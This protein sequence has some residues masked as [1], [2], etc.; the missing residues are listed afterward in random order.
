MS[1]RFQVARYAISKQGIKQLEITFGSIFSLF[2]MK[3]AKHIAARGNLKLP[4]LRPCDPFIRDLKMQGRRQQQKRYFK[5]EFTFLQPQ[6]QL[7]QIIYFV[8][9]T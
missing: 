2:P 9:V 6:L 3:V 7:F 4:A 8:K 5:S 1:L